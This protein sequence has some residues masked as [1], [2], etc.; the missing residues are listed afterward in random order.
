MFHLFP[1]EIKRRPV[2]QSTDGGEAVVKVRRLREA[3]AKS[4]RTIAG[5]EG[6]TG[7]CGGLW[8]ASRRNGVK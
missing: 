1:Q 6:N 2:Y 5:M 8:K 4:H 7:C 3:E